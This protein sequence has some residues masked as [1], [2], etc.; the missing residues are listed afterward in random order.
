[1]PDKKLEL[2]NNKNDINEEL[3]NEIKINNKNGDD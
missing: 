3:V 2:N 1:M